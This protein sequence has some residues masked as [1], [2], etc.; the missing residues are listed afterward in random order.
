MPYRTSAQPKLSI[1]QRVLRWLHLPHRARLVIACTLLAI[2]LASL[3][4]VHAG[5]ADDAV[6]G[7][8]GKVISVLWALLPFFGLTA[9]DAGVVEAARR[10]PT[11]P[12]IPDDVREDAS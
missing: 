3:G 9:G 7:I 11:R 6:I 5:L 2:D 10:D 4:A 8:K 12:A 1:W